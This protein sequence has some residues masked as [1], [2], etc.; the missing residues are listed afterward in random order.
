MIGCSC[1][2]ECSE[3]CL[4]ND[5]FIATHEGDKPIYTIYVGEKVLVASVGLT[6]GKTQ[7]NWSTA[8][9]NFSS[10]NCPS[11]HQPLMVYIFL[12][13]KNTYELICNMDQPFLLANGKY[14]TAEKLQPGKQL[15]DKDGNPVRIEMISIGSYSGGIHH[16][17]TDIPWERNPDGHLLLAG[18]VVAGDYT[19]QLHFDQLPDSMKEDNY[20]AKPSLGTPEY[21][22]AYTSVIKRSDPFFEFVGANS[23]SKDIG[24]RQMVSG[25][26]K[27]Y[28]MKT[29]NVPSEA[30]ALFT[31]DQAA[32]IHK[33]SSQVPLS[34]PIPQA[35]FKNVKDQLSGFYPDIEFYYDTLEVTPNVYAFE[36]D[37]RKIVQVSG[38][39]ARIKEF[40]YEGLFMAIAYGVACFYGGNPKNSFG[41]SSVG[42]AEWYA[43]SVVS[44]SCWIDEPHKTYVKAAMDQ[45]KSIFDLVSPGNAKDNSQDPLNDPSLD[46]RFQTIQTAAA[47]GALPKCAGGVVAGD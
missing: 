2:G 22:A 5:T 9:V 38:S 28:C 46:C 20:A 21:E 3:M 6:S 15:V 19:L 40:G 17:S 29:S 18:G 16:I 44:R 32:D 8:T 24:Q 7:I 47:G 45:W 36:F 11:G 1:F 31:P 26:F 35:T 30:Q 27:T 39:L 42:Q 34:N 10:E 23:E 14:T 41:Y 25:L 33:Y 43:F 37:G 4:A 12:R 13:G